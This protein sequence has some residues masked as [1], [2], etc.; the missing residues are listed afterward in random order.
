LHGWYELNY[1]GEKLKRNKFTRFLY[2]VLA[3]NVEDAE[4]FLL[5]YPIIYSQIWLN[6]LLDDCHF[7]YVTK[8]KTKTLEHIMLQEE[9]NTPKKLK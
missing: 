3:K 6:C 5:S 2:W 9:L 1:F 4:T 8:M 7:S